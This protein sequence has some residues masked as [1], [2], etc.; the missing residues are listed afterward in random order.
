[1]TAVGWTQTLP[2]KAAREHARQDSTERAPV[3]AIV[4]RKGGAGKT[5]ATQNLA[6]VWG[7]WGLRVCL[8]DLDTAFNLTEACG[9]P[10]ELRAGSGAWLAN[11]E[12]NPWQ[13]P[14]MPNCELLPSGAKWPLSEPF[15]GIVVGWKASR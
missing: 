1:M 8:I 13:V 5:T 15:V 4:N 7:T 6:G 12:L 9:Y 11:G 3:L 14:T 10:K 2:G